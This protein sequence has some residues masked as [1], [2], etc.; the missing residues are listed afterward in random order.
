MGQSC[1]TRD[2]AINA[3]LHGAELNQECLNGKTEIPAFRMTG[4]LPISQ[5]E[6]A[7]RRQKLRR[8][9]RMRLLQGVWRSCAITGL[10]AGLFWAT[11]LPDWVIRRPEQ[12]KIEGNRYLS[13]Q[14][15]RSL[16]PIDYPQSL[17]R[18]Q[19]QLI[20]DTLKE[21]APIADVTVHRQ[22]FPF[23]PQL[24]V[25]VKERYPVAL[26][27][28]EPG[29][30]PSGQL[31]SSGSSKAGLL[32]ENGK[33]IP[34]ER[35]TAL[36]QSVKLPT[37]RVLGRP[38]QYAAVWMQ[39]YQE[40]SRSPV[41]ISE[42]DWRDPTN[43]ILKTDLGTVHFGP[44]SNN[45]I[46]QLRALDRMRQLPTRLQTSQ[47]AYIDLRDPD[48]PSLQMNKIKKPVRSGTP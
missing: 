48:S 32:D 12:V 10:T 4:I 21:K 2:L 44:Y 42:V 27:L 20:V 19:P 13:A 46:T 17:L 28:P 43:L 29:S 25:Q 16:L 30:V 3:D 5:T 38:E 22:V 26:S 23:P 37:L 18:L 36:N 33:W 6:L 15:I 45:F 31:S 34:L 40:I 11:T 8:Q 7:Q 14:A 39:F 9:R 41:K 1:L 35:Y 47:I 24:T